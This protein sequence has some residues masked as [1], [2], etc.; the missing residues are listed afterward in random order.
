MDLHYSDF[1]DPDV[2]VKN[3]KPSKFPTMKRL[4]NPDDDESGIESDAEVQPLEGSSSSKR[5]KVTFSK[6]TEEKQ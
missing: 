2:K 6:D 1:F 3:G 5:R 4:A